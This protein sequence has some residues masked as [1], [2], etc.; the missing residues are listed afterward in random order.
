[1][2]HLNTSTKNGQTSFH[3]RLKTKMEKQLA[4]KYMKNEL[5]LSTQ[6]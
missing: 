2:E 6:N 3:I 1:M 5:L 4:L